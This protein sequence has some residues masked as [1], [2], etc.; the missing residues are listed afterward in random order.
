MV[1]YGVC[2]PMQV[3]RINFDSANTAAMVKWTGPGSAAATAEFEHEAGC[4]K[5]V[6]QGFY[7]IIKRE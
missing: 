5:A 6:Q 2:T 4:K 7:E 1:S 3:F